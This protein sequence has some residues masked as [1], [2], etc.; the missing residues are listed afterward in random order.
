MMFICLEK[1]DFMGT[2]VP[3][4][5]CFEYLNIKM[6]KII[7]SGGWGNAGE[8]PEHLTRFDLGI[9]GFN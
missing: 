6:D 9:E 2:Y 8:H 4:C 1:K 5:K 3:L 7:L